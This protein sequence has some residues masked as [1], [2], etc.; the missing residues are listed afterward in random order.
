MNAMRILVPL[1]LVAAIGAAV[2]YFWPQ[3]V[4]PDLRVREAPV[5]GAKPGPA[6]PATPEFPVTPPKPDKPLPPL[7]ESD[8]PLVEALGRLVSPQAVARFFEIEDIIRRTVATIDNLPRDHYAQRLNPVKPI[9]GAFL[10]A[11]P[12]GKRVIAPDN[13][14]RY[15]AFV[16]IVGA[17]DTARAV[18]TYLYFY[19]L[20]QQAYV[21][22][23]YPAGYFN[24]R[25][26]QV[27][28]HLL[29]TPEVK[30]PIALAVPHVLY[31]YAD[32]ALEARSS[33][34]KVLIRMGP[35]NA[36]RIKAKLRD[37]RRELLARA[38]TPP[39]R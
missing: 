39:A 22:L 18:D 1:A 11:G 35:E 24:D 8:A 10:A 2:W 5:A 14:K 27:I 23:G 9:G 15:T 4:R 26:V 19:P 6:K 29:E 36:A 38:G 12:E 20:F 34:Q 13:A 17:A 3:G 7:N 28:D 30:G 16:G 21:D 25:L 33:G 31:E 32:D 37:F